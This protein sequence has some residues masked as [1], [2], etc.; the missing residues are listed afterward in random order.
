MVES[1][2]LVVNLVTWQTIAELES[3]FAALQHGLDYI[4]D[5]LNVKH[6]GAP[7]QWLY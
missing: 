6:F 4:T 3:F 1:P 5:S 7:Q 2:D